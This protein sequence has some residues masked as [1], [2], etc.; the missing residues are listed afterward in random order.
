MANNEANLSKYT[1]TASERG[2]L[3]KRK[4]DKSSV[5][6]PSSNPEEALKNAGGMPLIKTEDG[7]GG[8]FD[9]NMP[10]SAP[11]SVHGV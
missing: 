1:S 5:F 7:K 10:K 9:T 11:G 3:A 4:S 6:S 2:A 8:I